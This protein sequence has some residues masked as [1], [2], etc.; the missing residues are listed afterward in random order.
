[1]AALIL[2]SGLVTSIRVDRLV[3]RC[4][5]ELQAARHAAYKAEEELHLV[6]TML[7][8]LRAMYDELCPLMAPTIYVMYE[9]SRWL[10]WAA[11]PEAHQRQEVGG[12][13]SELQGVCDHLETEAQRKAARHA[14][15]GLA[16]HC[17][18]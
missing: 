11:Q 18:K 7:P 5:R 2:T 16:C 6:I 14:V 12:A 17:R 1:M 10:D 8:S 3:Q 13:L 15:G 9:F 4:E